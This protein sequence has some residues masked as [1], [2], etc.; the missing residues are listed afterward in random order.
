MGG[1]KLKEHIAR[2]ERL[3]ERHRLAAI[4]VNGIITGQSGQKALPQAIIHQL[5]LP[6]WSRVGYKPSQF[7]V[8]EDLKSGRDVNL[9]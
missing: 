5:L 3:S 4:L 9:I 2:K 6:T 1:Q 7:H 8:R